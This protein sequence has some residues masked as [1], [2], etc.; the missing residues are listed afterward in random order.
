MDNLEELNNKI[1]ELNIQISKMAIDN[2]FTFISGTYLLDN[3][4]REHWIDFK[5]TDN[6]LEID[7]YKAT[8]IWSASGV[9]TREE[10]NEPGENDLIF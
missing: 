10:S 6:A 1:A 5:T 2:D 7:I 9:E 8:C 4:T 3:K